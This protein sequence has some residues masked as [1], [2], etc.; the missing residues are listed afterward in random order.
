MTAY[1]DILKLQWQNYLLAIKYHNKPY[2]PNVN[3]C[4]AIW[5]VDDNTKT[6]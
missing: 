2:I 4:N 3:S 6:A 1:T 5:P